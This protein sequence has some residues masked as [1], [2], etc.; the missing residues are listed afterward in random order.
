MPL[1]KDLY[2]FL[3]K[4]PYKN[5]SKN[6]LR[7]KFIG[8]ETIK[9]N[10]IKKQPFAEDK[11]FAD[12]FYS[13]GYFQSCLMTYLIFVKNKNFGVSIDRYICTETPGLSEDISFNKLQDYGKIYLSIS[14]SYI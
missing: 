14:Y 10:Q 7:E 4:H 9:S 12:K 3:L 2:I 5:S 6:F 13:Q 1:W 11:S 8:G